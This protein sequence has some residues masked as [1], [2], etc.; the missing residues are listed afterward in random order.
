[1]MRACLGIQG[2][3]CGAIIPA[4]QR[5]CPSCAQQRQR[6]YEASRPTAPERG[7]TSEYRRNR[8][9]VLGRDD[10]TCRYCGKPAVVVDHVIPLSAG[11]DS[12]LAN[13]VAA[14]TSC[15]RRRQVRG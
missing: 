7:Y 5:R 15:N 3:R 10:Y 6:A 4:S 13:L 11:G 9:I 14:C 12:S 2:N 1:M 8:A